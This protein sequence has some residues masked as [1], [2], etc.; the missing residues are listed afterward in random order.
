M[1]RFELSNSE[2]LEEGATDSAG[3]R[4]PERGASV[5]F[6]IL[7][8]ATLTIRGG[9]KECMGWLS[10]LLG[11]SGSGKK[12]VEKKY[13]FDHYTDARGT[14]QKL[15]SEEQYDELERVLWW[16]V[17]G[18]EREDPG[19]VAP[20]YYEQ[21]AI[22]YRK[23]GRRVDEVDVLERFAGQPHTRGKKPEKLLE[24]LEKLKR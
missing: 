19:G 20:Y 6:W 21:L 15:K 24:R 2:I 4:D 9:D 18:T 22:L 23:Q 3:W 10:N 1:E 5:Q 13:G 7:L 8:V 14:I 12:S 11:G 17:E 16:C